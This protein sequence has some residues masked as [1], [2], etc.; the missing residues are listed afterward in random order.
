[1]CFTTSRS[2]SLSELMITGPPTT[3][4]SGCDREP[5]GEALNPGWKQESIRCARRSRK[6]EFGTPALTSG[7]QPFGY[8]GEPFDAETGLLYLRARYYDPPTGRFLSRDSFG[9]FA[10]TPA[11]LHRYTYAHNNPVC[12]QQPGQLGAEGQVIQR[13]ASVVSRLSRSQPGLRVQPRSMQ[14]GR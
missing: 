13:R 14:V 11:S 10:S 12:A 5:V 3:F 9:G 1:M 8:T 2:N 7:S 4:S 6:D